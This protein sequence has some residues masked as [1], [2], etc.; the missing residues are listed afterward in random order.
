MKLLSLFVFLLGTAATAAAQNSDLGLLAV[1][2][3]YP[4]NGPHDAGETHA[5]GEVNYAWQFWERPAGRLY[6]ELPVIVPAPSRTEIHSLSFFVTPGVRYHYNIKPRI[7]LYAVAG[8]GI[9]VRLSDSRRAPALDWGGGLD[10]RLN[11]RWSVRGD[12]RNLHTWSRV[13]TDDGSPFITTGIGLH[14]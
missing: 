12:V 1:I 4:G 5:G 14:F 10:F 6:S 13:V 8:F 2:T 7:A 9:A 11:R 3:H